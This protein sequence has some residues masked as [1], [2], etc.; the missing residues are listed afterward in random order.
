MSGLL[1]YF[2]FT[3][4]DPGIAMRLMG[5][6]QPGYV[7]LAILFFIL[8]KV[9]AAFRLN[10][11]FRNIGAGL[12]AA[13][14]LRLYLLGMFYNLF[15]P[16]GIGGDAYKGYLIRQRFGVPVKKVVA[17]LLVD[18]LNG[19]LL[20]FMYASILA[21]TL[22]VPAFVPFYW[23]IF[24]AGTLAP[25]VFYYLQKRF[26]P[27]LV[28]VFWQTS[29][30]SSLVQLAQL[31]SIYF[32]M[33]SLGITMDTWAYLFIFLVSSIVAVLPLTIGGIGSRE[34]VFY[35][36]ALWLGLTEKV[37]VSISLMF[38]LITALVSLGG[39]LFHFRKPSLKPKN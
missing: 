32:V 6:A 2:V 13:S 11:Y 21:L 28:S 5:D 25:V 34:L 14:N 7:L 27:S 19:L 35:Y 12:T 38:F 30:L 23:L 16:G 18:R 22:E 8:S 4:I 36:G 31:L 3:K 29:A 33:S 26:F 17:A 24:T 20:L 15:L 10:F 39:I 37:S 1:L 9:L